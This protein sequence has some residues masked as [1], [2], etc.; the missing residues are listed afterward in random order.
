MKSKGLLASAAWLL[1]GSICARSRR[2]QI[3]EIQ[4]YTCDYEKNI[5]V[6]NR[7]CGYNDGT[8]NPEDCRD[9]LDKRKTDTE[10]FGAEC[11]KPS[12]SGLKPKPCAGYCLTQ[13]EGEAIYRQCL[14]VEDFEIYFGVYNYYFKQTCSQDHEMLQEQ[15]RKCDA[16]YIL[17]R[18]SKH[19][20]SHAGAM[21]KLTFVSTM[22]DSD[23][24]DMI[25]I[26]NS[27]GCNQENGDSIG[28]LKRLA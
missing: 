10:V 18:M 19:F 4:C 24:T 1:A 21:R 17:E 22:D 15:N 20:S 26:C 28:D 14:T 25:S 2:E 12:T 27:S 16:E 13:V 7:E 6:E 5:Y 9:D 11:L 8:G 23:Q 3:P